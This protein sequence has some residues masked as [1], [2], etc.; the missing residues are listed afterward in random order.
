LTSFQPP[1]LLFKLGNPLLEMRIVGLTPIA[2]V[3]GGDAVTVG[4]GLFAFFRG[5]F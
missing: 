5:E 3:L 1:V 4:A 2:R